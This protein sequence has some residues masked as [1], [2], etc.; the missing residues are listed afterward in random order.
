MATA[1]KM[2]LSSWLTAAAF[3]VGLVVLILY[4]VNASTGYFKGNTSTGLVVSAII[5]L[6][7][8]ILVVVLSL[9]GNNNKVVS[10]LRDALKIAAPV[11]LLLALFYFV[12]TRMEGLAY[13]YGSNS[14]ILATIQT[15]ENLASTYVA[16]AGFVLFGIAA[17]V[18]IVAAFFG[19]AK[20]ED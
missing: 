9:S 17:I 13:I 3:V 14:D 19:A 1:K 15:P 18:G 16:I 12:A 8:A 11:L 10:V 2:T 4:F 6:I 7:A 5:G 20:K